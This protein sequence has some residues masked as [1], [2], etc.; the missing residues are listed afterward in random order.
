[1]RPS[2]VTSAI[3]MLATAVSGHTVNCWGKALH[4]DIDVFP[5]AVNFIEKGQDR[6]SVRPNGCKN[7]YCSDDMSVR[8]CNDLD[9]PRV[10]GKRNIL[11]SINVLATECKDEY[12][13]KTVAGGVVDHSDHWSV[14]VQGHDDLCKS[15]Y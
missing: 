4:A 12:K 13:G 15:R 11:D 9:K 3:A 5:E 2:I 8:F 7:L 1:M 6:V 10:M 14:V